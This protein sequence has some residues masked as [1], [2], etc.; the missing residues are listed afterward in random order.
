MS[1]LPQST[2]R[3][4]ALIKVCRLSIKTLSRINLLH[5]IMQ[6]DTVQIQWAIDEVVPAVNSLSFLELKT[7]KK[8][9]ELH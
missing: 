2:Q 1:S 7:L 5:S 6:V 3:W 8:R 4:S 9:V